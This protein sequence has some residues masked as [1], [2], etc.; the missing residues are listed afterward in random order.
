MTDRVPSLQGPGHNNSPEPF[1]DLVARLTSLQRQVNDLSGSILKSAGLKAEPDLLRVLGSLV[2]EGNLSVPN[3]SIN[4][5]ALANPVAPTDAFTSQTN[6]A[7]GTAF[8]DLAIAQIAIPEGFT[9]AIFVVYGKVVINNTGS[10]QTLTIEC[11][12]AGYA[13]GGI[14]EPLP[15]GLSSH[16]MLNIVERTSLTPSIVST[17]V[18]VRAATA[19]PANAANTAFTRTFAILFRS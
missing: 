3:G 5:A 9:A 4:N 18:R 8:G 2:V 16:S 10:A 14:A 11:G 6:F 17:A 15:A 19:I 7:I 13:F 1:S 12:E